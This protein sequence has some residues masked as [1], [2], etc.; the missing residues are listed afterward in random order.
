MSSK[1]S[2]L[3]VVVG[4]TLEP[5]GFKYEPHKLPYII[6]KEYT[7]DFVYLNTLVEVKG[8]FRPGDTQKYK[9][10]NDSLAPLGYQLVFVL[11]KAD[12]PVRKGAKLT[13][14]DWCDKYEIPWY[15][16]SDLDTFLA[17]V[18]AED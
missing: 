3:E 17:D 13:M 12:K 9:A 8:Y 1:R 6:A 10:I 15:E 11:Q 4:A 16:V 7:P 14:G 5:A 18:L 2:T